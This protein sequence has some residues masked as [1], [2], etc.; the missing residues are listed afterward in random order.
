M[1]DRTLK[2]IMT[3]SK[4]GHSLI[5][6]SQLTELSIDEV[7][8][9][10]GQATGLTPKEVNI[11]FR[12]EQEGYSLDQISQEYG[13]ELQVLEQFLPQQTTPVIKETVV[14]LETQIEAQFHQGRRPH[15]I[16]QILEINERPVLAYAFE[17][18]SKPTLV[19]LLIGPPYTSGH[20]LQRL[21]RPNSHNPP[22]LSTPLRSSTAAK[23]TPTNCTGSISSLENS[24][25]MKCLISSSSISVVGV[26]CPEEVYSSL[27]V[28]VV[29][30]L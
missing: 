3:K 17:G 25:A 9:T 26:S 13:V 12:M 8:E 2:L 10:L 21:R 29:G 19:R 20:L 4:Q 1:A 16:A 14:G 18:E 28:L 7:K 27:V 5:Q 30:K 11:I 24:P 6:I 23:E 22:N 15:E